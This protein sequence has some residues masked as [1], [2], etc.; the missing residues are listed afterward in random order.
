[1]IISNKP[2]DTLY[3]SEREKKKKSHL[4]LKR[5]LFWSP[6]TCCLYTATSLTLDDRHLPRFI[7]FSYRG[8]LGM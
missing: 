1:M 6:P 5:L 3:T 4:N 8:V 2:Y 7:F